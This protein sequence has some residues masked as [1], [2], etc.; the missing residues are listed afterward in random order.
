MKR[1]QSYILVTTE[2]NPNHPIIK[3]LKEK[4][5]NRAEVIYA[6]MY[7]SH[8]GWDM[9]ICDVPTLGK[10]NWLGFTVKSALATIKRFC[11]DKDGYLTYTKE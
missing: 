4:G 3:A 2:D 5:I 8:A 1:G 9:I 10:I 7:S 11:I 6:S